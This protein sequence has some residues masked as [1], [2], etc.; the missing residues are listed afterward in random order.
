MT[1]NELIYDVAESVRSIISDDSELDNRRIAFW[2]KNQR[3]KYLRQEVNKPY[4]IVDQ[5]VSQD[6]GPVQLQVTNSISVPGVTIPISKMIMS[7]TILLPNTIEQ[8]T[9]PTFTRIGSLDLVDRRF[10]LI[11][12]SQAPYVGNGRLNSTQFFVF[13]IGRR[14]YVVSNKNNAKWKGLKY[15]NIQGVFEDP[16]EAENLKKSIGNRS[17]DF[18]WDE[19]YPLGDWMIP[20]LKEEIK[21]TDLR[22][23]IVPKDDTNDANAQPIAPANG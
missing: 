18:S 4:R 9:K 21:K 11:D 6:L 12:Y 20:L 16:E 7:T 13:L 22:Q 10:N 1:L 5:R 2:I 8:Y 15:L 19:Y 14:M 17:T 3:A 23:F